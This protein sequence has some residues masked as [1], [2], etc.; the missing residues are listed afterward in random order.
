[1]V[2]T[3]R[4]RLAALI[5]PLLALAVVTALPGT[6]ASA[7][8][9]AEI[10]SDNPANWTPNVL[11][12]QVDA[13]AQVGNRI[14]IG[15]NFTGIQDGVATYSRTSIAAFNSTTGTVDTGFNPTLDGTVAAIVPAADGTSVYITGNF[16][17]VNGTTERK[18]AR[19]NVS[20]GA[21]VAGFDTPLIVNEVRDARLVGN[22]LI[23][24]GVFSAVGNQ[25]R[26]SL[27]SLNATTGALTTLVD[28]E[29]AGVHNGGTTLVSKMEVTP[30]GDRL[31]VIGNFL[32][33]EG[34][35]RDQIAMID[36]TGPAATVANWY[37]PFFE[38][39]CSNSFST[40]MRDLDIDATGTF[41]VVSTTG[42]YRG[43][44]AAGVSCDTISR[45]DL[46]ATGTN[47]AATW[48]NYT[49]G[50]TS[51]AVE[52]GPGV[53][54]V[55]GHMRWVNNPYDG[56]YAGPGAIPREG[57]VALD[58]INGM[59]YSWDP[60]RTRG[61]GVFD[62]L[63]T[64]QGLWAGSDTDRWNQEL[65]MKLALF[66]SFNGTDVEDHIVGSLPNHV[67]ALG[68]IAAPGTPDPGVLYRIN[69]GGPALA[70]ADDG[71]NWA[72]DTAST[73]PYRN[74]GSNT[75]S[76]HS[77]HF[78]EDS[79]PADDFDRVPLGVFETERWD[80]STGA[81]MTWAFPVSSG[82]PLE[83]RLYFANRCSCTDFPGERVFDVDLDGVRVIE[84]LD[85]T[86]H[87]G[88]ETATMYAFDVVSDGTVDIVLRHQTE[89]PLISAIEIVQTNAG[90]GGSISSL[91]DVQQ[92][93]LD[94]ATGAD[95]AT[96]TAGSEAWRWA[97]GGFMV[98]TT[99]YT[100]WADG[101]MQMRTFDNGAWGNPSR[102]DLYGNNLMPR[103]ADVTG[104]LFDPVD[105]RVYYT[106]NGD[107]TLYWR[108]FTPESSSLGATA[109]TASGDVG[110][111]N[112][113]RVRG[114][115]LAD[116][117]IYFADSTSGNLLRIRFSGGT[118]TGPVGT[119]DS[120]SD[121]RS[122]V[123]VVSTNQAPI[124]VANADCTYRDCTL[125]SA[126]SSDPDGTIVAYNWTFGDGT[127]GTGASPTH[128]YANPGDYTVTLTVTDGAGLEDTTTVEAAATN[129]PPVASFTV[130]CTTLECDFDGTGSSDPDG[131]IVAY[132]WDFGDGTTGTGAA[133][134]RTYDEAG[135]Y[136]VT[137][138]VTDNHGG[139]GD[140]TGTAS[141]GT[142]P[143]VASFTRSCT[144]RTCSFDG[145]GSFDPDG[146]IVAYNWNFGDGT[147]GTGPNP[148]HTYTNPGTYTV[149][150][151]VT[152][153]HG[154]TDF[155]SATISVAP[156]LAVHIHDL[157]PKPTDLDGDKW[158]PRVV[159][160]LRDSAGNPVKGVDVTAL[161]G[162]TKERSCTTN[163]QGK[164]K[165]KVKI[166]DTKMKIPVEILQITWIGGYDPSANRE[167]D[168][169][170]NP[171]RTMIHFPI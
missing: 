46:G 40:F 137:L 61:V 29:F 7:A 117:W 18:V 69:A 71:P 55:G 146:T 158:N 54:Y 45:W 83:V 42:A 13:I 90:G 101:S 72:A 21:L 149:T 120:S 135:D 23:I 32:T 77:V 133:P 167:L 127:T 36:L 124:A 65:R 24:G 52:I 19:I 159:V 143:P 153:N 39:S 5:T 161:F 102:V 53:V 35:D 49:G 111:L 162:T 129:A 123:L 171:E 47:I 78:V 119:I 121:W 155:A 107:S 48:V 37:T 15:G 105:E 75:S 141:P 95:P 144:Y 66:P 100:G 67:N 170:G 108:W 154:G 74:S 165:M 151:T 33:V 157:L 138:T 88:H 93:Y 30:S 134:T 87:H 85:L 58:T 51:Y 82:T 166:L 76:Y 62:M 80:P 125:S 150:L 164:C 63:L 110:T 56:D 2:G 16:N 160:K 70:S 86:R 109:F 98:N 50:D 6:A 14:I 145:T 96:V 169:D 31:L 8:T 79:V 168:G 41:A 132:N 38:S 17:T 94:P 97:R 126:G 59:P 99:V 152:D 118:V 68:R 11:D 22:Q 103:M 89:N 91:D 112:P 25:P 34:E 10:V 128:T 27:A 20:T 28:L 1:M 3:V 114:M 64:D 115:V 4:R 104:M 73:S 116:G 57:I 81:E 12:G 113:S 136:T 130:D 84:D 139:T 163:V 131:T 147:T 148:T 43:G 122:R 156:A 140:T 44:I 106:L 26:T 60:G 92:R 9:I 142:V